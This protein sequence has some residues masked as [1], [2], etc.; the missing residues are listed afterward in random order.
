MSRSPQPAPANFD[1]V[2]RL[3][4]WGEYLC[5]GPL[6]EQTRTFH[7]PRLAACRQALVLGDGD[8][9]FTARLLRSNRAVRVHAVDTSDAMLRLLRTRAGRA[10]PGA[11][12]RLLTEQRS[13][14]DST[15]ATG[16]DLVVT[17]FFLDCLQQPEVDA[18][19]RRLTPHLAPDALWLFSDFRIPGGVLAW[20]ARVYVRALY[21]VLGLL[22][23]LRTTHLPDHAV[24]L[25]RVGF[26]LIAQQRKL[27]GM[28]TTELWQ[29][30][31]WNNSDDRRT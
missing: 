31:T 25:R 28:L 5:L 6:L 13:A 7:L 24:A 8:G 10:A 29:G 14:L 23:G 15:P 11:G 26:R 20:P 21:A 2:A 17:H 22:T 27:F 30:S 19:V 16:T 12:A 1:R 18:L 4:R 9:R 3:Y